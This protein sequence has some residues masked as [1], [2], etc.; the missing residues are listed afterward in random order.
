MLRQFLHFLGS[1]KS[2]YGGIGSDGPGHELGIS[3]RFRDCVAPDCA[4]KNFSVFHAFAAASFVLM[5]LILRW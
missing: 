3:M 1:S 4:F 5:A 2:T